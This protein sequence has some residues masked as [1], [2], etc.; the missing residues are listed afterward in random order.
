M[1]RAR[2]GRC[3]HRRHCIC[4]C[5]YWHAHTHAHARIHND[6]G[7][8][9]QLLLPWV[10]A[11]A[12]A[13]AVISVPSRRCQRH[14]EHAHG[15]QPQPP[16]SRPRPHPPRP[17]ILLFVGRPQGSSCRGSQTAAPRG[18]V[19]VHRAVHPGAVC[20]SPQS[21]P[22]QG[23]LGIF[24]HHFHRPGKHGQGAVEG[25]V[26]LVQAEA[27]EG[28]ARQAFAG[29]NRRCH[30]P[31]PKQQ[32]QQ[33][34]AGPLVLHL[35]ERQRG[36]PSHPHRRPHQSRLECREIRRGHYVPFFRPHRGCRPFPERPVLGLRDSLQRADREAPSR[37]R[38]PLR[39]WKVRSH[40][41]LVPRTHPAGNRLVGGRAREQGAHLHHPAAAQ[42]WRRRRHCLQAGPCA[43]ASGALHGGDFHHFQ[44]MALPHH[45]QRRRT[46]KV[47]GGHRQCMASSVGRI[48]QRA[49][50]DQHWIRHGRPLL[51]VGRCRRRYTRCW[52]DL[53]D[54]G[55]D[56]GRIHQA[57]FGFNQRR[58]GAKGGEGAADIGGRF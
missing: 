44:G 35:Q 4:I 16:P 26:G 25:Q 49:C 3:G 48:L 2:R 12:P 57:A 40:R 56:F 38:S 6:A 32:R 24:P 34:E 18:S 39:S 47:A 37:R 21:R 51:G 50:N 27:V 10:D 54:G 28:R 5:I 31:A 36:R 30:A 33:Q 41:K 14:V 23:G 46:N 52:H 1:H 8:V 15:T 45:P 9:V 17:L 22:D 42:H 55:G 7:S 43:N 53:N 19:F 20:H 13:A 58:I 11:D 29:S